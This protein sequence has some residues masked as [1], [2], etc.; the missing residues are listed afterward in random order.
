ME[1]VTHLASSPV[2][3]NRLRNWS[4]P[5]MFFYESPT[6][7]YKKAV[8]PAHAKIHS[9]QFGILAWN[10]YCHAVEHFDRIENPNPAKA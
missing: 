6:G 10:W 7:A 9:P 4:A 2:S 3:R 5:R 1:I 8:D